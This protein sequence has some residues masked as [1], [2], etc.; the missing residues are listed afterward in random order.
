M[1]R[2]LLQVALPIL[3][4]FALYFGYVYVMRRSGARAP[5]KLPWPW[6]LGTGVALAALVV[7]ALTLLGG[8][9]PGALYVPPQTEDGKIIPGH[10]E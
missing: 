6:L 8:A 10:F 3:L 9:E 1:T 5:I 7:A 4:P 2:I